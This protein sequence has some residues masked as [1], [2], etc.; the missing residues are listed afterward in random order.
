MKLKKGS[1]CTLKTGIPVE[2]GDSILR[3]RAMHEANTALLDIEFTFQVRSK[4]LTF[5]LRKLS[6][7][8]FILNFSE[9]N[10]RHIQ[11][12][13]T[14]KNVPVCISNFFSHPRKGNICPTCKEKNEDYVSN[15]GLHGYQRVLG[16]RVHES[17]MLDS[18]HHY[19]KQTI[20]WPWP[21]HRTI[22]S[23]QK[24]KRIDYTKE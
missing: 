17:R 6:T 10:C 4:L 11:R 5:S 19:L 2:E 15:E 20:Y 22:K 12:P 24:N 7:S 23:N 21:N 13:W 14:C 16:R 8:S 1:S 9:C 18:S 3:I